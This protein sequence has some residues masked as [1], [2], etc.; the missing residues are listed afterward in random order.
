MST[1]HQRAALP[2]ARYAATMIGETFT[3][4]GETGTFTAIFTPIDENTRM[5]L[6]G[7]AQDSTL[8]AYA[9]TEQFA[10]TFARSERIT[11]SA[12]VYHIRE[13]KKDSVYTTLYLF[14]P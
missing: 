12:A 3:R 7:Y 4:T 2:G 9:L 8:Q 10:N 14:K 11:Y 6:S 5:L 1:P 13:I